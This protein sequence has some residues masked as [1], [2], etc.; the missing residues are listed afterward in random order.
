M[1]AKVRMVPAQ[2]AAS[3]LC[4]VCRGLCLVYAEQ[5]WVSVGTGQLYSCI[6]ISITDDWI[7]KLHK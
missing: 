5:F 1:L 7:R 4:P 2:R 3:E 6:I